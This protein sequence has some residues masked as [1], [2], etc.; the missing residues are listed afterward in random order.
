MTIHSNSVALTNFLF[1]LAKAMKIPANKL[2]LHPHPAGGSFGSKFWAVRV[3]V[4][5]GMLEQGGG[6]A[7]QVR[8]GQARQPLLLRPSRLGALLRRRARYRRGRPVH[9]ASVGRRRRLRR[10]HPVRAGHARKRHGPGRWAVPDPRHRVPGAGVFTNKCQQGAYRGFG[11]EVHNFVLERIVDLAARELGADPIDLRRRNFIQ[12][13]QFPYKIPGGN[14]YDS[15]N[16]DAVLDKALEPPTSRGCGASR[17]ACGKKAATSASASSRAR[18]AASTR[19][20][21]GGSSTEAR[22]SSSR[23]F[24]RASRSASTRPAVSPR[25]STRQP[26]GATARRRS[27]RS[28]SPRSSASSR[29]A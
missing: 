14:E 26:S 6:Q 23:A 1:L 7:R 8:R 2:D 25:R 13:E 22:A 5:T 19:R 3:N 4:L 21:S 24:P 12:P 10:L 11:S 18:N 29:R 27:S 15:G 17:S 28:A 20:T 16:Y 9:R